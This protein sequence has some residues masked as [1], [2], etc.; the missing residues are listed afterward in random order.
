MAKIESINGATGREVTDAD[1]QDLNEDSLTQPEPEVVSTED[2]PNS[3]LPE[4]LPVQEEPQVSA[5]ELERES[6]IDRLKRLGVYRPGLIESTDDLAKSYTNIERHMSQTRPVQV[7]PQE[8][9]A[10]AYRALQE[11]ISNDPA[12]AMLE[13]GKVIQMGTRGEIESLREELFFANRPETNKYKDEIREIRRT[14]PNIT[15]EDAHNMVRGRHF[16]DM[17]SETERT[18]TDKVRRQQ[19]DKMLAQ[20]ERAGGVRTTPLSQEEKLNKLVDDARAKGI[21]G[22]ALVKLMEAALPIDGE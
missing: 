2:A 7:S 12:A 14:N 19:T 8:D 1:L 20:R 13:V 17:I 22:R 6:E 3:D 10:T 5:A 18:T 9:P 11:M 21:T 4:G 15:I 16:E